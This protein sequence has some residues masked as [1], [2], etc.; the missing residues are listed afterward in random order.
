MGYEKWAM[1][2]VFSHFSYKS[3]TDIEKL[4]RK[5]LLDSHTAKEFTCGASKCAYIVCYGLAPYF[6][7][8]LLDQI[9]GVNAFVI[10]LDES[11][12]NYTQKKQMDYLSDFMMNHPKR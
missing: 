4:F 12:N 10:L 9:R 5:M 11:M 1:K 7:S 6:R 3:C 8:Q 2:V